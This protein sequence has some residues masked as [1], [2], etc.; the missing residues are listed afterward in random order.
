MPALDRRT[1][2]A[3]LSVFGL[4]GAFADTLWDRWSA[5]E[6]ITADMVR[7]AEAVAGLEF[8]EEERAMMLQGLERNLQAYEALRGL[9]IPNAV[10]P[11]VQFDP[12]LAHAPPPGD[13]P[14]RP[15]TGRF[16]AVRTSDAGAVRTPANLEDVAFWPVHR[17]AELVRSGRVTSEALTEMYL[18]R[19]T[20]H[21]PT[22]EAVVTRTDD[23]ALEQARRADRE[24]KAG[25]YRGPLHGI[26]WGAKD[27][28]ATRDHP[29][30][31]GARAY[32]D[33]VIP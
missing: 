11:A 14:F 16:D 5:Q 23:L 1:F 28:L 13:A 24:L 25:R 7:D 6:R 12:A 15:P 26:P 31:W 33:Q 18:D 2:V 4:G 20:R 29:T 32:Q 10:P 27:L 17:L 19:L 3:Q 9:E 30:T 21:G 22:L 8:T